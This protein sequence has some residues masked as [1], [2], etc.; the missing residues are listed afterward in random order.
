MLKDGPL[1]TGA[2]QLEEIF[3]LYKYEIS[4]V[5]CLIVF[6][7]TGFSMRNNKIGENSGDIVLILW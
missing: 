7:V 6:K 2:K 1:V 4:F 3:S 5:V